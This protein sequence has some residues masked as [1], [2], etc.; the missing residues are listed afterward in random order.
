M[1][2]NRC[3][4]CC[5]WT[6]VKNHWIRMAVSNTAIRHIASIFLLQVVNL[7]RHLIYFGFYTFH[8]LLRLTRTLL[9]IL[10]CVH[11]IS[12]G[13]LSGRQDVEGIAGNDRPFVIK[14]IPLSDYRSMS[15][16]KQHRW[17]FGW[18]SSGMW[19]VSSFEFVICMLIYDSIRSIVIR[20]Y[21]LR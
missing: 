2:E 13:L 3:D 15:I 14:S 8:D 18:F 17:L 21:K 1:T 16:H 11:G 9:R 10:D 6:P 19:I 7:A 4:L 20:V 12:T 5:M